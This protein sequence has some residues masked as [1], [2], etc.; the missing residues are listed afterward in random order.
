MKTSN[1][2]RFDELMRLRDVFNAKLQDSFEKYE[3]RIKNYHSQKNKK[4]S[5]ISKNQT[6][7]ELS[8]D[9]FLPTIYKPKKN[10]TLQILTPKFTEER[11]YIYKLPK[12]SRSLVKKE[13]ETWKPQYKIGDYFDMFRRLQDK[14]EINNWEIVNNN[15]KYNFFY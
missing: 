13:P 12:R 8:K 14:H 3:S 6:T 11:G 1:T 10:K 15:Y 2:A 7:L 5:K 9:N 4:I